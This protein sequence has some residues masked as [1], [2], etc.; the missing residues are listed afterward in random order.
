MNIL[1][2]TELDRFL[3]SG[4]HDNLFKM[5]TGDTFMGR[6]RNGDTALRSAL[7]S[8]VTML[9]GQVAAP[10]HQYSDLDISTRAKFAPMVRGI[11]P[12]CEQSIILDMLDR[13]VV[14]LTPATINTVLEKATW[15]NTAWNLANIYLASLG[16][17]TLTDDAQAIVGLSEETTCYVSMKYF[18]NNN[19]FE[20]YVIHEAAHIFHNCKRERIGL[21]ATRRREWL[22]EIDYAKRETFAY[23]CEAYS[24]ILELGE[25]R[26]A[27]SRLLSELA[28]EPMPPDERVDG[29]EYVDILREAVFARNGWKRIFERCSP[30]KPARRV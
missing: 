20:D 24:R 25:T 30:V 8:A 26:S 17:K 28:E 21:P 2:R 5:W 16:A 3:T 1:Q 11:F 13:S 15:L 7:I 6:A 18:S 10:A 23:S 19:P 9:A 27:R 22:L 4:S 12:Q 14:F 29:G